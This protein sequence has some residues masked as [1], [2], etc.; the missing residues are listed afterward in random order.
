MRL[1][2]LKYR[3]AVITSHPIQYQAPL[4]RAIVMEGCI[5]L[6]VYFGSDRGIKPVIDPD[7][8]KIFSW[9]VPLLEGYRSVFLR[10]SKSG[11]DVTDWR[12]DGPELKDYLTRDRFDAVVIYGWNKKLCW[13]ASWWARKNGIKQ[14]LIGESNLC[15]QQTLTVRMAKKLLFNLYFKQFSAFLA[16]GSLNRDLYLY[17]GVPDKKI[18]M[19]P[20]CVDNDFFSRRSDE[21]REDAKLLRH[22]LGIKENDTVF[23]FMAKLIERKRPL[24]LIT[25]HHVLH[26][27]SDI[28]TIIV[29]DGPMASSCVEKIDE[30][31]ITNIHLAGFRNQTE[32]PLYY[33]AADVLVLPSE[34]ETWGLV[35]NEAM[36]SGIPCI[37][38]DSC[39]CAADMVVSGETGYSYPTGDIKA[40]AETMKLIS[41]RS[42]LNRMSEPVRKLSHQ[43]RL[44]KTVNALVAA[45]RC[46]CA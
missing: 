27:R 4:F 29:G 38:S 45:L 30:G 8:G 33:A 10:N 3:L 37:V 17:Y 19:A 22:D 5:D 34:Y 20:Y 46:N 26:A 23:L 24:D 39:G 1:S 16:I 21:V 44:E 42:I 13:Q 41:D 32:L 12:L 14:I 7:F 6:T 11:I 36:A 18:F 35:V 31:G 43:F 15:H 25:A 40:L 2:Q 9:D 28:H